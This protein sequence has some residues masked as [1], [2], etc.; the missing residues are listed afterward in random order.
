MDE[1]IA[2]QGEAVRALKAAKAPKDQVTAAVNVLLQLK[3]VGTSKMLVRQARHAYMMMMAG[4]WRGALELA[5]VVYKQSLSHNVVKRRAK[6]MLVK[7]VS[8]IELAMHTRD[9]AMLESGDLRPII[10]T[11]ARARGQPIGL[12]N[13]KSQETCTSDCA[14]INRKKDIVLETY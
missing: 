2:R 13:I 8:A 14:D 1:L 10:L 7:G 3:S 9:E 12:A 4:K 6:M 5:D 11:C